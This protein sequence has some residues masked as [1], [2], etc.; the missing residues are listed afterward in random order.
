MSLPLSSSGDLAMRKDLV[1]LRM[2]MNRQQVL[3]HS[4]PLVHPFQR[5]K[6]MVTSRGTTSEHHSGK[7]PLMIAATVG[8]TLFGRRLGK[9][10]RLARVGI[11]LY[12][13]IRRLRH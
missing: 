11:M 3:Y 13:L 5:I 1:R 4:Q 8:L 12:P 2:E 7:G 9:V 6:G 10:G